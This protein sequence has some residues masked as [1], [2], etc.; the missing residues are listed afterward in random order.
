[1][2]RQL[3]NILYII[4][5][6]M[7]LPFVLLIGASVMRMFSEGFE[8]KYVNSAF[9]GLFGAVFSY[10]VGYLL[11]HMVYEHADRA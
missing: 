8:A 1:M 4:G 10:A 6:V 2:S 3:G 9:L 11:R 5:I 7:A